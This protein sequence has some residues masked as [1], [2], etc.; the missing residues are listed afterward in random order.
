M[1]C[2][3][4]AVWK[5]ILVPIGQTSNILREPK[6]SWQLNE[7]KNLAMPRNSNLDFSD[8]PALCISSEVGKR[9]SVEYT[10]ESSAA[11]IQWIKGERDT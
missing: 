7:G 6:L 9:H 11:E 1:L 5:C 10:K 2:K 3:K 4:T 8:R